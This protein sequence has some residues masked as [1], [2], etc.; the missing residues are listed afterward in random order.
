V[1]YIFSFV[2]LLVGVLVS[3]VARSNVKCLWKTMRKHLD[4]VHLNLKMEDP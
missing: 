2:L 3:V 4:L 1:A